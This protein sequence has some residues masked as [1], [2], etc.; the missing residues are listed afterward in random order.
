MSDWP[1][2]F[3]WGTGAS[4]TQTEGASPGSDWFAWEEAGTGPTLR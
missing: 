2:G 3:I 1:E 4:S